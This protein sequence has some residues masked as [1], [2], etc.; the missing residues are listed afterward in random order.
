M[1][2]NSLVRE[3]F[4]QVFDLTTWW[5]CLDKHC[6]GSSHLMH[7]M[8][9]LLQLLLPGQVW[10]RID[11]PKGNK[12]I[13]TMAQLGFML[14]PN[15]HQQ[16]PPGVAIPEGRKTFQ[17]FFTG[18]NATNVR[19]WPKVKYHVLGNKTRM[20]IKY[21]LTTGKCPQG[22]N[23][24]QTRCRHT[25]GCQRATSPSLQMRSDPRVGVTTNSSR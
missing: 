5:P 2:P 7:R 8:M 22:R 1:H 25:E 18:D 24:L 21:Y 6:Q 3:S 14:A 4:F 10:T 9:R 13:G 15:D 16:E 23:C 20:C 17:E 12:P 19:D 11:K